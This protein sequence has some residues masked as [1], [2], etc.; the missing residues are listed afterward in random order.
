MSPTLLCA[1]PLHPF[2]QVMAERF[3]IRPH[4]PGT[5][6]ASSEE[7]LLVVQTVSAPALR[8]DP[9]GRPLLLIAPWHLDL[10]ASAAGAALLR[11]GPLVSDLR[12]HDEALTLQRLLLWPYGNAAMAWLADEDLLSAIENWLGDPWRGERWLEGPRP[13][14]LSSWRPPSAPFS[15]RP[16]PAQ[17][18]SPPS[19]SRPATAMATSGSTPRSCAA[20]SCRPA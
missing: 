6:L 15:G 19:S 18:P 11:H 1:D 9:G 13:S 5:P 8:C 14:R 20:H 12:P 17:S 10:P 4:P 7:P 2:C 16:W 3:G